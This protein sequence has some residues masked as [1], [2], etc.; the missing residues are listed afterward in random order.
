MCVCVFVGAYFTRTYCIVELP[1]NIQYLFGI[2]NMYFKW[3]G[4]ILEMTS[5]DIDT[6]FI[7]TKSR[8]LLSFIRVLVIELSNY[9]DQYQ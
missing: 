4:I 1:D 2:L 3:E 8:I 9:F 7:D 5:K 6:C